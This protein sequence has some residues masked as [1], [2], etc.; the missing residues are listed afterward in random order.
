M[1]V[2]I[3]FNNMGK[4]NI[5]MHTVARKIKTKNLSDYKFPFDVWSKT[6]NVAHQKLIRFVSQ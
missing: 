6:T 1:F 2:F 3:D 5:L 4:T